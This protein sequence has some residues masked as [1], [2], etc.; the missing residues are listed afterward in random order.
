MILD[1]TSSVRAMWTDPQDL[2]AV[3][4]DLR[5]EVKPDV[6]CCW[7]FLP[8]KN[9]SFTLANFDPPHMVYFVEGKPS[10]LTERFGLLNRLT[11]QKDMKDG[12]N[13]IIRVLK[14]DCPLL[15]KWNNNHIA[16]KRILACF[17]LQPKFGSTV[18][19]SRGF[20]R[21]G[22]LEPRSQT[23]WFCFIKPKKAKLNVQLD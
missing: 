10:F 14:P 20:R 1:C 21:K 3:F 8:F 7:Q 5:R 23:F 11:W 19:G 12:F 22:S 13:E 15:F 6:V 16:T 2:D 4:I 9:K 18:N 17:S